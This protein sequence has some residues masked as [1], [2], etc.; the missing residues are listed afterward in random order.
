ML[1]FGSLLGVPEDVAVVAAAMSRRSPFLTP[2]PDRRDEFKSAKKTLAGLGVAN[3]AQSDHLILVAAFEAWRS[4]P[5]DRERRRFASDNFLHEEAMRDIDKLRREFL[6]SIEQIGFPRL[7]EVIRSKHPL[8]DLNAKKRRLIKASLCAGL[9]PNVVKVKRPSKRYVET[10]GGAMEAQAS[11][12]ELSFEL[13]GMDRSQ[14]QS[15]SDEQLVKK[16]SRVFLHPSSINFENNS[17]NSSWMVYSDLVH[18]SKPF[19]RDLTVVAPY[20]L[21][22]FGGDLEVRHEDGVIVVGKGLLRFKAAP[23]IAVLVKEV[24]KLLDKSLEDKIADPEMNVGK[25]R[26]LE[27]CKRLVEGDGFF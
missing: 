20:G 8:L 18:T 1:L 4:M 10:L 19:V 5:S 26:V 22:L 6:D 14:Q 11:A 7:N 27:A 25:C 15:E 13:L 21:L 23:R 17:F 9:Y 12:K 3:A 24:R 2:P 16:H